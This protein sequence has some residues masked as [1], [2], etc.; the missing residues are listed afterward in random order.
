LDL[1]GNR[2]RYL[3]KSVFRNQGKLETLILSGNMLESL[4]PELFTD[5]TNLLNLFL[6]ANSISEISR[7]TFTGLEHL[8]HLDLSNNNIDELDPLVF[9]SFNI[10]SNRQ[11]HQV[12]KLK[13]LNLAENKIRF[14]NFELYFPSSTNSGTSNP[15]YELVS[16]NVSS[17]RLDSLDAASVRWL[18]NT[19]AFTDLSGNPWKCEC[20]AL[21][22]AWRELRYKLTL[23]CASSE[24]R[25]GRTW[26]VIEDLCPDRISSTEF[27]SSEKPA[28]SSNATSNI[29]SYTGSALSTALVVVIGLLVVCT[30]VGLGFIVIQL[31]KELRKKSEVP[32]NNEQCV[33]LTERGFLVRVSSKLSLRSTD[34]TEHIY[35]SID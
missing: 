30:L 10:S 24:E 7:S 26:D 6:S 8:Q 13:H 3:D 4:G 34:V 5:C 31:I 19:A 17:N 23:N 14:F 2:I 1:S 15:M 20:S 21:G 25:K 9:Q 27:P 18:K 16:L 12:S 22:E 35:E 11:N 33:A 32:E 29:T 28:V